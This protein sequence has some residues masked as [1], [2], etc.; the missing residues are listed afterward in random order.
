MGLVKPVTVVSSKRNLLRSVRTIMNNIFP[1]F[2]WSFGLCKLCGGIGE[3]RTFTVCAEEKLN[4]NFTICRPKAE[5]NSYK[6]VF[7]LSIELYACNTCHT[8]KWTYV[9]G[10][11]LAIFIRCSKEKLFGE[12]RT[13]LQ[14]QCNL[15]GYFECLLSTSGPAFNHLREHN[16]LTWRINTN[17]P[18]VTKMVHESFQI[19][20]G[21]LCIF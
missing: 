14:V 3:L 8:L 17:I 1:G 6:K 12:N 5:R 9:I 2:A 11:V 15:V 20:M 4:I 21:L 13:L 18:Q 10:Y 7:P 16:L 19:L